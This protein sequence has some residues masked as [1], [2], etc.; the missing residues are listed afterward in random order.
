MKKVFVDPIVSSA[1]AEDIAIA[2]T[3][4]VYTKAFKIAFG[5]DFAIKY[6]AVSASSTPDLLIQIEQGDVEP[7]TEGAADTTNYSIA[8][9]VPNVE[10]N[11]VTETLHR[12][13]VSLPVSKWAR[14][15]I[16][17]NASNPADTIFNAWIVQQEEL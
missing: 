11:L 2:S 14:L 15:K 12:K 6:K 1:H 7:T 13:A 4:V 8:E 3:V 16:T 9:G 10:T 5:G 17:G